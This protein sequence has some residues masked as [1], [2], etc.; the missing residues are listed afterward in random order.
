MS[1]IIKDAL[2]FGFVGL[3]V[4]G[5]F[6]TIIA[7]AYAV[8][9]GGGKFNDVDGFEIFE[10]APWVVGSLQEPFQTGLMIIGS[11]AVIG[12]IGFI[13]ISYRPHLTSHGSAKWA[14]KEELIKANLAVRLKYLSGPIYAKLGRPKSREQYITS[15][16]ITHRLR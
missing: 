2:I 16:D 13:V 11:A 5:V 4:G 14:T 8:V 15:L 12:M 1:K 7:S 3:M 9:K 10:Y 6:G